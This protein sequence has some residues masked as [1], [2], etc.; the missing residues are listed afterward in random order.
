M[1]PISPEQREQP[2]TSIG[3]ASV[4][5]PAIVAIALSDVVTKYLAHTRLLP[6]Y[7]PREL[8]GDAVRLTL[9]GG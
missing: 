4:F 7:V 8:L 5:W 2:R 9:V 1:R 6:Q 3:I